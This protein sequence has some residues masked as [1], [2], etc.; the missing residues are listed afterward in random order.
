MP[1]RA[2][3]A[4]AVLAALALPAGAAAHG[5]AATVA[6]DYRLQLARAATAIPGVHARI[7]DGD[8][9]LELRVDPGHVVVVKGL[10]NEPVIRIDG[11]GTWVNAAS[12]TALA[13]KLVA[14]AGA[15][16][17]HIGTGRAY[18]WHDHRLAPPPATRPGLAG[19]FVIP[20]TVDGHGSAIAGTFWRSARPAPWPWLA[21][22]IALVG[23]VVLLARRS[24]WR[25]ALTIGLGAG[26][27]LAALVAVTTFAVRD[28]PTGRTAWLQVAAGF[29]IG[30]VLVGLLIRLHGRRRAHAAGVVGAIAAAASIGSL[31]VFWHGVVI[32]ALPANL[33]RLACG[34]ALVGGA[35]AAALSFLPDFD[36]P[37]RIAR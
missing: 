8:R 31:S 37:R 3:L 14:K 11:A 34:L 15:G 4:L 36:E 6:L 9:S 5:R 29:V 22:A 28:A 30:I 24:P 19:R 26:A 13:D 2:A 16:W 17:E 32:S 35:A 20:I 27:G 21:G 18:A 1:L 25:P 10:L 23:A 12:A 7:L 33:A